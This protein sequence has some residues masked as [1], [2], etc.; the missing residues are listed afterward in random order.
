MKNKSVHTYIYYISYLECCSFSF[1]NSILMRIKRTCYK[2]AR[3]LCVSLPAGVALP[4]QQEE[5][6]PLTSTEHIS[7]SLIYFVL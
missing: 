2:Q 4:Q 5:N 3:F 6:N 1:W 7:L